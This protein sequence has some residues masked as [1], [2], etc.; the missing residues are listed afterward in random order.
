[1][2]GALWD[3]SVVA[4]GAPGVEAASLMLQDT[5]GQSVPLLLWAAWTARTGRAI[6]NETLEAAADTA[7]AWTEAAVEPLRAVRVRMKAPLSDLEPGARE[8]VRAEVKRVELM[9][10]EALLADLESLTDGAVGHALSDESLLERLVEVARAWNGK[11][12]RE[13]LKAW[14]VRLPA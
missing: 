2:S 3:W 7:K 13:G 11:V 9:A 5:A 14:A 1:M 12:P 6:D 10:E 8:R 4:Y